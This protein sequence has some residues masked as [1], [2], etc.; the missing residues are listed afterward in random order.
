MSWFN[1][2]T[3][4]LTWPKGCNLRPILLTPTS[5]CKLAL[6]SHSNFEAGPS[7][8][9][10]AESVKILPALMLC[11]MLW[12]RLSDLT[13]EK[14]HVM[15]VLGEWQHYGCVLEAAPAKLH[16]TCSMP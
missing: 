10:V 1:L 8:S 4:S 9:P 6:I 14:D 11:L 5:Q 2:P 16:V 7:L 3:G 12:A 15:A 13:A